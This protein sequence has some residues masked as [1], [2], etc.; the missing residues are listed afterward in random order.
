MSGLFAVNV[1]CH[2]WSAA[3]MVACTVIYDRNLLAGTWHTCQGKPVP[4][5]FRKQWLDLYGSIQ[6]WLNA[7]KAGNHKV[8]E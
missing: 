6:L 5:T 1:N 8:T 7:D 4:F 2:T 3:I